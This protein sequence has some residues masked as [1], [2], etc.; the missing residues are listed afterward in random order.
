LNLCGSPQSQIGKENVPIGQTHHHI[1]I[2][3][4]SEICGLQKFHG[5]KIA[6]NQLSML[7]EDILQIVPCMGNDNIYRLDSWFSKTEIPK[8]EKHPPVISCRS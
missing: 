2:S 1:K 7:W 6:K 3:Q 4:A 5:I 8:K